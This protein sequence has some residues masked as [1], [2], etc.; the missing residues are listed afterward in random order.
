MPN[1][2]QLVADLRQGHLDLIEMLAYMESNIR[3]FPAIEPAIL[4]LQNQLLN[5]LKLQND[6]LIEDLSEYYGHDQE[7]KKMVEF[8]IFDTRELKIKVITFVE[9]FVGTKSEAL[10][11]LFPKE[12]MELAKDIR[13]RLKLEE[14]YLFPLIEN[15]KNI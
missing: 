8:F 2:K 6:Q 11:H 5:H 14:D 3:S 7:K 10:I 15:V 4:K 13:L 1:D 12:G 9:K